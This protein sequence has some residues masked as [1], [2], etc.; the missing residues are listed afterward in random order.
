M[1][2]SYSLIIFLGWL[3]LALIGNYCSEN[4]KKERVGN[5]ILPIA[6]LWLIAAIV[7]GVYLYIKYVIKNRWVLSPSLFVVGIIIVTSIIYKFIFPSE[8]IR[9]QLKELSRYRNFTFVLLFSTPLL[10]GFA[11]YILKLTVEVETARVLYS[12]FF[13]AFSGLLVLVVMFSIFIIERSVHSRIANLLIQ[14]IKGL[15]VMYGLIILCS[16]LSLVALGDNQ[17]NFNFHVSTLNSTIVSSLFL[18]TLSLAINCIWL[19]IIVFF[20]AVDVLKEEISPKGTGPKVVFEE[21]RLYSRGWRYECA[22]SNHKIYGCS[23]FREALEDNK[24]LV[25]RIAIK[26][27]SY[28]TLQKHDI[29]VILR[30]NGDYSSAEIDAIEKFVKEGGGLLLASGRWDAIF[31]NDLAKRFGVRF[32]TGGQIC[33]SQNCYQDQK[34]VPEISEIDRTDEMLRNIQKFYMVNGTYITEIGQSKVVASSDDDAWFEIP[35][36]KPDTSGH[37]PVLSKME[38]GKGRVVFIGS[39]YQWSNELGRYP[40]NEQLGLDIIKWL[41]R[42]SGE[43]SNNLKTFDQT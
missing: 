8:K 43:T 17:I 21:T 3:I 30:T 42:F 7:Y 16:V 37:F 20:Q 33:H 32:A 9:F 22:I 11:L 2:L 24:F 31:K 27:I 41:A 26:P 39:Y 28:E 10:L 35:G 38:Y 15:S 13:L 34:M 25:S 4:L 19:T 14:S 36:E 40:D 6:A 23:D 29:L 18:G 1:P 5:F 12:S